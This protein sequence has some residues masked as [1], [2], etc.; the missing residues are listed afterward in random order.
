VYLVFPI[1]MDRYIEVW[2]KKSGPMGRVHGLI[3][4]QEEG[5]SQVY[6]ASVKQKSVQSTPLSEYVSSGAAGLFQGYQVYMLSSSFSAAKPK[7]EQHQHAL[8]CEKRELS[9]R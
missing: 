6:H 1:A 4:N 8:D 7:S 3:L 5:N 9:D 2:G